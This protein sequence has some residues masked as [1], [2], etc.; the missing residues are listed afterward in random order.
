VV[1]KESLG[2][3]VFADLTFPADERRLADET[4]RVLAIMRTAKINFLRAESP[5]N[6]CK[7]RISG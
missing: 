7:G 3:Q 2:T 6:G 1:L 5:P 4:R